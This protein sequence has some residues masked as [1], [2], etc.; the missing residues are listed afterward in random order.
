V[1]VGYGVFNA[2][3]GPEKQKRLR[4]QTRIYAGPRMVYDG[5]PTDLAIPAGPAMSRM[6]TKLHLDSHLSPGTYAVQ[7]EC[8][9]LLAKE[10]APRVTRQSGVFQIRE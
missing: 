10:T 3:E 7:V 5:A 1:D 9:D 6:R 2:T 4:I 8:T